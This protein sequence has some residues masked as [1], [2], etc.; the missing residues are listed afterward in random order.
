MLS[1]LAKL[2]QPAELSGFK[3]RATAVLRSNLILG[4]VRHAGSTTFGVGLSYRGLVRQEPFV[5]SWYVCI[6]FNLTRY[7]F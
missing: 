6:R 2:I 7:L 4:L 5:F 1:C 3:R